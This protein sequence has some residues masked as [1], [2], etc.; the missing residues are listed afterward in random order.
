MLAVGEPERTRSGLA[1]WARR[2]P[3]VEKELS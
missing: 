2:R 3:E 1:D